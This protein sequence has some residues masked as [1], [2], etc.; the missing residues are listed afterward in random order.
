MAAPTFISS[1]QAELRLQ[2]RLGFWRGF[3]QLHEAKGFSRGMPGTLEISTLPQPIEGLGFLTVKSRALGARADMTMF[4]PL[5]ART[6]R[7]APLV[8]LLHGAHGSHW[9]WA[10]QGGAH[11]T[12]KN[13]IDSGAIPPMV[14]AMPSDGL[15]GDG[16]GYVPHRTQDFEKWIVEEV[17]A[18]AAAAAG[19]VS[20][21]SPLF[22]GGLS[23]GGFGAL[24]I[25]AKY[26][27]RYGGVSAHS[28]VTH[29]KQLQMVVEEDLSKS[30][31]LPEDY[32]VWDM[33]WKARG[34]LPPIRFD[35]GREDP[36]L[37]LN[38][39]LHR[40]MAEAGLAHVYEEFAGGHD[41]SYWEARLGDSLRFFGA[42]LK[43]TRT[44]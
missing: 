27:G 30:G 9:N 33:M 10:A 16:S 1:T 4:V 38:R 3:W 36:F 12:A 35:C 31:V 34:A 20:G 40:Q 43:G 42:I 24:R 5:Q 15:W 29:L 25:G 2:R 17:P 11:R 21:R 32:G 6:L 44:R 37:E 7:D 26:A 8:V 18:A 23:M 22:L 19:C 13:L 41:W 39:E 28:S 14:L